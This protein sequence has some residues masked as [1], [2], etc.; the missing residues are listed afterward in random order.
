MKPTTPKTETDIG[1]D[2]AP[3]PGSSTEFKLAE[4]REDGAIVL[5]TA[6]GRMFTAGTAENLTLAKGD[7]LKSSTITVSHDGLVDGVPTNPVVTKVDR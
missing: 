4:Q 3:K 1:A 6:D 2:A 5:Q 7:V